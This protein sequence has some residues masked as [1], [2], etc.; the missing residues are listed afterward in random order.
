MSYDVYL[1]ACL[2]RGFSS[3]FNDRPYDEQY[4]LALEQFKV[5]EKS[6]Y[7]DTTKSMYECIEDYLYATVENPPAIR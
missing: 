7:N 3:E 6:K 4:N 1:F 5:F 2:L